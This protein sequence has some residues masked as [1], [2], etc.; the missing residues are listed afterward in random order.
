MLP[1]T[2]TSGQKPSVQQ[3]EWFKPQ[4]RDTGIEVYNSLTCQ[5]EKFILQDNSN[6]ITWYT[7]GPTVYDWSHMGHARTYVGFDIVRR[8]LEDYFNFNV[9][10]IENITDIDDKII[11]KNFLSVPRYYEHLFWEDMKQLQV[12]TPTV[13]VRVTEHIDEVVSFIQQI[14]DNGFAYE[15]GG[16]VYFDVEAFQQNQKHVYGKLEPWNVNCEERLMDGEGESET[17][18]KVFK[19]KSK[20]DFALWKTSKPGEPEWDSKW[21]KGRPGWHIE[22]S[23]MAC[24][25]L[26]Q[27]A[28]LAGRSANDATLDVHCGGIDL[29]FP[30]HDNELAQSEAYLGSRQWVNYF[31]HTGHLSIDGMSMSKSKKNFITIRQALEKYTARQIRMMFLYRKFDDEMEYSE[32]TMEY[33]KSIEKSFQEFFGNLKIIFR[34][35]VTKTGKSIEKWDQAD[36]ELSETLSKSKLDVDTA[37]RNSFDTIKCMITLQSLIKATNTYL[38]KKNYPSVPLLKQVGYYVTRIFSV[39]GLVDGVDTFGFPVSGGESYEENVAPIINALSD[40][41]SEIR[42]IAR[43][44]NDKKE[45]R[46]LQTCDSLRDDVLPGLGIRLEDKKETTSWKLADKNEL[47][48]EREEKKANEKQAKLDALKKSEEKLATAQKEYETSLIDPLEFFKQG[49]YASQFSEWDETG[50]PTKDKD[51]VEVTKSAKKNLSKALDKQKK[52][53]TQ[54]EAK[55]KAV[56]DAETLVHK[57]GLAVTELK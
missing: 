39:F 11:K 18:K 25:A 27:A 35:Y 1:Q 4:G 51:G 8:I 37:L 29:K 46:I 52:L 34:D 16:N 44:K 24:Y 48:R 33:A 21:G 38:E 43:D 28:K 14:I 19:K 36:F 41:R 53:F 56:Q 2:T 5:K 45:Q 9:I 50:L 3:P 6:T 22:C 32:T 17:E 42:N 15:E 54:Q 26:Q 13:L 47:L 30:H 55:K 57:N 20:K 49:E 7:C 10:Y 40:F 23:A 12:K 31:L